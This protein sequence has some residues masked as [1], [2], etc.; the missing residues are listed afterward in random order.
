MPEC[1]RLHYRAPVR[2]HATGRRG[3][4]SLP[5][6]FL[7]MRHTQDAVADAVNLVAAL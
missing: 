4:F 2:I 7:T 1:G 5:G 3:P 6:R